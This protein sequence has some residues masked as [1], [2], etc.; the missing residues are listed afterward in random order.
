VL[1]AVHVPCFDREQDRALGPRA[2]AGVREAREQR[3]IVFHHPGASP[4]LDPPPR[5]EIEQE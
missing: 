4:D 2:I 5:G 1:R 3:R